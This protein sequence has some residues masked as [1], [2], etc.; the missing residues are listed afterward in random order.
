M[1]GRITVTYYRVLNGF[2]MDIRRYKKSLDNNCFSKEID[3]PMLL[4]GFLAC[5]VRDWE[6]ESIQI[7]H[8]VGFRITFE[9]RAG[10]ML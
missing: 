2:R 3:S 4:N 10:M 7:K 1:Q 9:I 6:E 8:L 5:F